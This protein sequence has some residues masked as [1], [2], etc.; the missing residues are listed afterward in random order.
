V[1]GGFRF[2]RAIS[3]CAA[4]A[5]FGIGLFAG[6][7]GSEADA[8]DVA[9]PAA[10]HLASLSPTF[11]PP[12]LSPPALTPRDFPEQTFEPFGV[13]TDKLT[14]GSLV[15]KWRQVSNGVEVEQRLLDMCRRNA[16]ACV[17][18][19]KRFLAVI[20]LGRKTQGRARIGLINRA[21]NLAIRPMSDMAQYGIDDVWATPLMTF[22][23]GAGDCEDYAIA[24]YVALREAGVAESDLRLVVV[25][26]NAV[27]DFH[28]VAAVR[29]DGQWLILDNRTL[30]IRQDVEVASFDPLF[31]IGDAGVRRIEAKAPMPHR[32]RA[33]AEMAAGSGG[34]GLP[35]ML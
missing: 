17:P 25:R 32:S 15:E 28:A 16:E 27:R 19:A 6:T 23:S 14:F 11:A 18:A 9:R 13:S 1:S 21:V 31:T 7:S 24:K 5:T 8:V 12:D 2:Q 34:P 3:L 30:V 33:M 35:L 26:D 20:E 10:Y 4:L 29:D 22:T